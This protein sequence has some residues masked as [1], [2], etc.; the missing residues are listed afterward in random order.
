MKR[1]LKEAGYVFNE[2][3]IDQVIGW[4][5]GARL[6]RQDFEKKTRKSVT[7][8]TAI[9]ALNQLNPNIG[10]GLAAA[11]LDW[12]GFLADIG[13]SGIISSTEE[14]DINISTHF[15]DAIR[16]FADTIENT[17]AASTETLALAIAGQLVRDP[18]LGTM[19]NRFRSRGARL[20]ELTDVLRNTME[21]TSETGQP[22]NFWLCQFLST[23]KGAEI[24]KSR[25]PGERIAWFWNGRPSIEEMRSGD[26]VIYL[27]RDEGVHTRGGIAGTGRLISNSPIHTTFA[28]DGETSTAADGLITEIIESFVDDDR[29]IPLEEVITDPPFSE[30]LDWTA[31]ILPLTHEQARHVDDLLIRHDRKPV[32][33]MGRGASGRSTGKTEK[34][35]EDDIHF[36]PDDA[37]VDH[38]DLRR[39]VLAVALGRRLHRIWCR[40]NG[41]M[42]SAPD[43]QNLSA[44]AVSKGVDSAQGTGVDTD[45]DSCFFDRSRDNTRAAFVLHLDAP[46]GGG[47]TTFANFLTRVLCP[48]G[49]DHVDGS[50]LHRRYG[51][52]NLSSIFLQ[53]PVDDEAPGEG[54]NWPD[55]A[56]RPWIVVPFNAWQT[57]HVTPPWWV[58]YQ[59]IRKRCFASAVCEGTEP[60]DLSATSPPEKPDWTDRLR[61]WVFLWRHEIWWRLWNPKI[62]LL[63]VTAILALIAFVVLYGLG[64]LGVA[65]SPGKTKLDFDLGS[66]I[67]LVLSGLTLSGSLI[68]GL[69][70]VLTDSIVPG[71][72]SLAERMNIGQGDP[73]ER[74][75]EHFFRTMERVKRPVLVVVDDIDRCQPEFIVEIVR[76][77]QTLLRSPRIVFIVLGDRDWIER[78]F[79]AHHKE[80]SKVNVGPEQ[81]LGA[82]FV[83]KAIQMSFTLPG[84]SPERQTDYVTRLLVGTRQESSEA[85][86]SEITPEDA[87][88]L[89]TVL[90]KT[91]EDRQDTP[92]HSRELR[93]KANQQVKSAYEHLGTEVVRLVDPE[94]YD[95]WINE[96]MAVLAAVDERAEEE[97]SHRL[98]PLAPFF[99]ANPRQIKRIVNAVTMY[100]AVAIREMGLTSDDDLWFQ[101][102]LWLVVMTEWPR[103]WRLVAS[104]PVLADLLLAENPS[105]KIKTVPVIELPGTLEATLK[106]VEFIILDRKLMAL[107]TGSDNREGPVL[108]KKAVE[109]LLP[110]IPIYNRSELLESDEETSQNDNEKGS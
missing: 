27:K 10:K 88:K 76:G 53:D 96:E 54:T 23:D 13:L 62:K 29:L 25:A 57:E 68:W 34:S 14:T 24:L 66:A 59:T 78:A 71:T 95:T 9:A 43:A 91:V 106:K 98:L 101:L 108:D 45:D 31:S 93:Q 81:T 11:G 5:D 84:M 72:N 42:P 77:M 3:E 87:R 61:M 105:E 70:A 82:R 67:G 65:G 47:K 32:G 104:Y 37:E 46:W 30:E 90:R 28:P 16:Q 60:I 103:T 41:A 12:D 44:A 79:E 50:F 6:K 110:L 7:R 48:T 56:R 8:S 75:R 19:G 40:L 49:Y 39:G 109:L 63:G 20:E 58:F 107:L 74:F 83:E 52:V 94:T 85:Q 1:V 102:A 26:P 97:V 89:R 51:S 69:S 100:Q 18:D 17:P 36:V 73:F 55:D 15:A 38:D 64:A 92:L 22:V 35:R 99:P 80:M 21:M 86:P 33:V 4:L 2:P